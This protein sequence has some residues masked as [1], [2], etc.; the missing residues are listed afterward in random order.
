MT[1]NTHREIF[2][3]LVEKNE[4]RNRVLAQVDQVK[5]FFMDNRGRT[6]IVL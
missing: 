4:R 5:K 2:I 6:G 3:K 1:S